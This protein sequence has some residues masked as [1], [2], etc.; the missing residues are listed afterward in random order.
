M[1]MAASREAAVKQHTALHAS[2]KDVAAAVCNN[3]KGCAGMFMVKAQ[4]HDAST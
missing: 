2:R 4:Q 3:H 1:Q